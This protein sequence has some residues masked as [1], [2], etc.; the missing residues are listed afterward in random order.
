[1]VRRAAKLLGAGIVAALMTLALGFA[2]L[3]TGAGKAWL[4]AE[5]GRALTDPSQSVTVSGLEGMVPFDLRIGS[6]VF[7]DAAG[8]RLSIA[9]ARIEIAP[10]GLLAGRLEIRRFAAR[11]I[12][13]E[14]PNAAAGSGG[15]SVDA[16]KLLHPP[17]PISLSSLEID[18]ARWAS[19]CW[20]RR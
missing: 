12:A 8:P 2:L 5:I 7:A 10:R 17:L 11:R 1:M 19:R 13:L 14:R 18:S 6:I 4:A 3:Q 20:A 16:A 9:D 15:S